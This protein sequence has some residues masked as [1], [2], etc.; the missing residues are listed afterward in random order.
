MSCEERLFN[1]KD[2]IQLLQWIIK[3]RNNDAELQMSDYIF[4][5][6]TFRCDLRKAKA[7]LP[8]QSKVNL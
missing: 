1:S 6:G 3:E 5:Y 4:I 7:I 8:K 2:T